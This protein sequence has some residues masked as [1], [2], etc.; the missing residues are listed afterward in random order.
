MDSQFSDIGLVENFH[1][2]KLRYVSENFND[3]KHN[4]ENYDEEY[5]YPYEAIMKTI[6]SKTKGN[7]LNVKYIKAKDACKWNGVKDGRWFAEKSLSL[8]SMPRFIR[9]LVAD[10]YMIDMDFVN[11]H[12]TILEQICLKENIECVFLNQYNKDPKKIRDELALS[13]GISKDEVKKSILKVMNGGGINKNIRNQFYNNLCNELK[14]IITIIANKEEYKDIKKQRHKLKKGINVEGSTINCVLCHFENI[15]LEKLFEI[16]EMDKV[17]KNKVCS[18]EFDG[19]MVL[20]NDYNRKKLNDTYLNEVS[21]QIHRDCGFKMKII[22]K[23]F[24][25]ALI[26]P[27]DWEKK[28]KDDI[29]NVENDFEA[30]KIFVNKFK[31][32]LKKCNNEVYFKINDIWTTG[33]RMKEDILTT[34][35]SLNFMMYNGHSDMFVR[36]NHSRRV[37]EDIRKYVLDD[38]S[39]IDDKFED[40]IAENN[41]HK[42]CFK[43]CYFDFEK[44]DCVDINTGISEYDD[45][46][47]CRYKMSYDFPARID[48]NVNVLIDKVFKS[49]MPD[50]EQREIYLKF[51]ARAVA[52]YVEDKLWA[53]SI[54]ERNSC[55]GVLSLACQNML[56]Q[57]FGTLNANVF[58]A[59]RGFSTDEAKQQSYLKK[60]Q[61]CKLI[62]SN[63]IDTGHKLDGNKIKSFAS[64]GDRVE[65]RTNHKDEFYVSMNATLMMNMNSLPYFE[66]NTEDALDNVVVFNMR[67]KFVDEN[68]IPVNNPNDIYQIADP[69]LKSYITTDEARNAFLHAIIQYF[70]HE[71]V[72]LSGIVEE[73]T[74]AKQEQMKTSSTIDLINEHFEITNDEKDKITSKMIKD[75]QQLKSG[76]KFVNEDIKYISVKD[77]TDKIVRMGAKYKKSIRV[78]NF[79]SSGWVGVKFKEKPLTESDLSGLTTDDDEM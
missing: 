13:S 15:C 22:I 71:K 33:Q 44:Y 55:K 32:Y 2:Q 40:K 7:K 79:V 50:K 12:P 56:E 23:P 64:G 20:D 21:E 68:K 26:I 24:D 58:L 35:A 77:I 61:F 46:I 52:G 57:Y 73:D 76:L 29:F 3:Y 17:I 67:R 72:K 42:I 48:K 51:T 75:Y 39:Y 34:I 54:G 1:A 49:A 66:N 4:F 37:N 36:M 43:D 62:H 74:D 78:N 19:L 27:D 45:N 38:N 16:L 60:C 41:K 9:H 10:G 59:K 65:I 53:V 18:L 30:S 11:C 28:I 25:E 31:P 8:Q 47:I 5:S 70:A 6:L 63:E 14:M 69:T